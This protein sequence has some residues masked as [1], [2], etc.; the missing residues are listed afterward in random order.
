MF[1]KYRN[2]IKCKVSPNEACKVVII[3]LIIFSFLLKGIS[4]IKKEPN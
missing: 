3:T 2:I 1:D 4:Q